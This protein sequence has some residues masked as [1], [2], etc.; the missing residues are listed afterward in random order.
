MGVLAYQAGL[1]GVFVDPDHGAAGLFHRVLAAVVEDC[2]G[3]AG[4][5]SSGVLVEE[6]RVWPHLEVAP[7]TAEAPDDVARLAVDL[8]ESGGRAGREEQVVLVEYVYRV[9]VEVIVV[10]GLVLREFDVIQAVPLEEHLP[11]LYVYFLDY[12]VQ[13]R[14]ISGPTHRGQVTVH[15]MVDG[16]QRGVLGGDQELVV[17]SRV[18][19]AGFDPRYLPVGMVA[20][21]ALSPAEAGVVAYPPGQHRLALV[22]LQLEVHNVQ[23]FFPQQVQ[24]HGLSFVVQDHAPVLPRS[25][26]IRSVFRGD[27]D[28]AG[29]GIPRRHGHVDDRRAEI[30]ARAEAP[31]LPHRG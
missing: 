12:S 10:A 1:H 25:G 27:E 3:S 23:G 13:H 2:D 28:Q 17:V 8:E 20:D 19:V 7:L 15:P 6:L 30:R 29:G 22:L 18:A 4:M 14:G 11:G 9:E 16:D 5:A 24:P 26:L 31:R 21:H